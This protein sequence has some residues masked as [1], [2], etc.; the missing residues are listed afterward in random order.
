[1]RVANCWLDLFIAFRVKLFTSHKKL[2]VKSKSIQT[3]TPI[4]GTPYEKPLARLYSLIPN[5]CASRQSGSFRRWPPEQ[6]RIRREQSGRMIIF[7]HSDLSIKTHLASHQND[8]ASLTCRLHL[9]FGVRAADPFYC[10][11]L[12]RANHCSRTWSQ[13]RIL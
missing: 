7:M 11:R 13:C 2:W 12:R 5:G 10:S 3:W 4:F 1:M 6:V 9:T 8:A